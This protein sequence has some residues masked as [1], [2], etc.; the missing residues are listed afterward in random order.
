MR[1]LVVLALLAFA[2]PTEAG[3]LFERVRVTYRAKVLIADGLTFG[4]AAIGAG[5]DNDPVAYAGFTGYLLATP[6]IHASYGKRTSSVWSLIMR[7]TIPLIGAIAGPN[8]VSPDCTVDPV[9]PNC[10][11]AEKRRARQVGIGAGMLFVSIIDVAWLARK[12]E[13]RPLPVQPSIMTTPTG[14]SFGI[15]GAF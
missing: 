11:D 4:A 7:S 9:P 10:G 1:T 2:Q 12:W 6:I 8:F 14:T 15:A 5:I 13:I 3:T